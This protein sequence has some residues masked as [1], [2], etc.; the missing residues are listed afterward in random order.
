MKTLLLF[1]ALSTLAL[2]QPRVTYIKSFPGS[3]PAY[4]SITVNQDGKTEYREAADDE[5]PLKFELASAEASQIFALAGKLDYFKR[6]LESGLKVANMGSKIFRWENGA[7][8]YETK[9]NYTQDLDARAL[10]DWFE[11]ITETELN[12]VTLQRAAR[13][14]KLGVYKLLLQLEAS[15]DRKR[16]V[17]AAQFLPL[18]DRIAKNETY[19]HVA[20]ERAASL[21]DAI[22]AA[23]KPKAE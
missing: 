21:A 3:I 5:A 8:K 13:F 6:P 19:L 22:R 18:L 15:N 2:A 1:A 9:F 14:D 10:H 16:L 20:R 12:L 23:G 4:V 17:A 7:E 11:K